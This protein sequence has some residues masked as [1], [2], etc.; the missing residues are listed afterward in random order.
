MKMEHISNRFESVHAP[1]AQSSLAQISALAV[2]LLLLLE[3]PALAADTD[4]SPIIRL[5]HD[6]PGGRVTGLCFHPD[7]KALY[8]AGWSK[9][10]QV[11]KWNDATRRYEL[12][13]D[14]TLRV[15]IGDGV[16]GVINA[17]A[18]S[19]DGQ[20]LAV[21]GQGQPSIAAD[22]HREGYGV[23]YDLFP[24]NSKKDR[25][26]IT[27]FDT[28]RRGDVH[29]LRG[30]LASVQA[31]A[32]APVEKNRPRVVLASTS[33]KRVGE[34]YE[35][36]LIVWDVDQKK[37][38]MPD[39]KAKSLGCF[40]GEPIRMAVRG[41]G[42]EHRDIEVACALGD[43][44]LRIWSSATNEAK[45][46]MSQYRISALAWYAHGLMTAGQGESKDSFG[47]EFWEWANPNDFVRRVP[48][49]MAAELFK[50]PKALTIINPKKGPDRALILLLKTGTCDAIYQ[51]QLAEIKNNSV[52]QWLSPKKLGSASSEEMPLPPPVMDLAADGSRLAVAYGRDHE[53]RIYD[54]GEAGHDLAR[55]PEP[56]VL[57]SRGRR[58]QK[59][60]FVYH[61]NCK[62]GVNWKG[63]MLSDSHGN[64]WV[65]DLKNRQLSEKTDEWEWPREDPPREG[66]W[67]IVHKDEQR[68]SLAI[69]RPD[70]T[71]LELKLSD[72]LDY[73]T[74]HALLP[75]GKDH[76]P[77]AAVAG[78]NGG[79]PSLGL[80][81]GETG[82]MIRW[83]D[84]HSERITSLSFSPDGKRLVSVS[85]DCTV[86]LWGNPGDLKSA[87]KR[88]IYGVYYEYQETE[89]G[90][91]VKSVNPGNVNARRLELNDQIVGIH[92][93]S[94]PI[95]RFKPGYGHQDLEKEIR[96]IEEQVTTLLI[97]RGQNPEEEVEGVKL[98]WVPTRSRPDVS[99][100]LVDSSP[101]SWIA[102]EPN[103]SYDFDR[104]DEKLCEFLCKHRNLDP[105]SP[106]SLPGCDRID[107]DQEL[108]SENVLLHLN[109]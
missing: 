52:S 90:F 33:S 4:N 78:F 46:C 86:R 3:L 43:D 47:L 8:V 99:L 82:E 64:K 19:S 69:R 26:Q 94:E 63:L 13:R 41:V 80:Y 75:S 67:D 74:A 72:D 24:D 28:R 17:M 100:F 79:A 11:W 1:R 53:V 55:L 62:E 107:P 65:I 50:Q 102:W 87:Q 12:D 85:D 29:R 34:E 42:E 77:V 6:G 5:E 51:I 25:G 81:D 60:F 58:F 83:L 89:S 103:G 70:K 54:L 20:W 71:E 37:N 32:F 22:P 30:H 21:G 105:K 109:D 97:K 57:K 93:P 15:R 10:V 27:V 73:Y 91:R 68:R 61:R 35:L 88:V 45:E 92:L 31:L 2:L 44:K 7:S 96:A 101:L 106:G 38:L 14:A 9:T 23:P 49:L 98:A 56:Q 48:G 39:L 104:S 76:R 66:G 95:R 59:A 16:D 84:G 40:K 36:E 18:L 108:P